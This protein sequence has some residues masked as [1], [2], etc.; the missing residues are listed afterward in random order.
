MTRPVHGRDARSTIGRIDDLAV[1]LTR[2]E[3][4]SLTVAGTSYPMTAA[5]PSTL[6]FLVA[7]RGD[8]CQ[9]FPQ[10]VAC[11]LQQEDQ[12]PITMAAILRD[13]IVPSG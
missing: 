11:K 4:K 3:S 9:V 8:F 13:S 2:P 7:G 1:R 5:G 6:T 10:G 12:I